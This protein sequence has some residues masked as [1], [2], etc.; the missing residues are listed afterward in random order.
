MAEIVWNIFA[1]IGIWATCAASVGVAVALIG[2][3]L[4]KRV[5]P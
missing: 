4:N 1:G 3:R 5:K 2:P